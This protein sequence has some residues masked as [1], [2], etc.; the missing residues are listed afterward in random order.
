MSASPIPI[1]IVAD[2][3]ALFEAAQGVDLL[4][5]QLG[6]Q[7][8]IHSMD[9]PQAG[10]AH[11]LIKTISLLRRQPA[12]TITHAWGLNSLAAA[13]LGAKGPILFSAGA[14]L[15]LR[16]ISWLRAMCSVRTIHAISPTATERHR[17][18][19]RGIPAEHCHIIRPAVELSQV[20]RRRD[21]N[22]RRAMGLGDN[23][24]ALL[25]LGQST[26]ESGHKLTCWVTAILHVLDERYRLIL[27][28]AGPYAPN[29]WRYASNVSPHAF[30]VD[31]TKASPDGCVPLGQLFGAAD[32]VLCTPQ[33][34]IPTL[35]IAMAMASGLPIVSTATPM[36]SELLEDHHTAMMVP[37]PTARLLAGRVLQVQD[38]ASLQWAITDRAK[39][40]AY[41]Y[42][43]PT[44]FIGQHR[45]IYQQLADGKAVTLPPLQ[46]GSGTRFN[47]MSRS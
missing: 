28:G 10:L 12:G 36:V 21:W 18:A 47:E 38:D 17:W 23:D 39:T 16:Q 27:P 31:A 33:D 15:T 41:E 45:S 42:F 2:R 35:P 43:S 29:V 32:L 6:D 25:A 37:K 14:P 19:Q 3:P 9:L 13:I 24:I 26:R 5:R 34:A 1:T 7:F 22:L 46:Q 11:R 4:R 44:T 40:E 30:A 8:A 20:A